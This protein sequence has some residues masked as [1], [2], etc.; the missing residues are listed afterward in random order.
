M[1]DVDVIIRLPEEVY[2]AYKMN[3]TLCMLNADQRAIAKSYLVNGLIDG[4][5]LSKG[6]G[7]IADMD[8]AIKC[9]QEVKGED[10][11]WAIAL[12]EWACSKRIIIEADKKP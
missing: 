6:H 11:A 8:E 3:S 9:I 4:I 12:I 5:L 1:A 10:A 2:K 7:R